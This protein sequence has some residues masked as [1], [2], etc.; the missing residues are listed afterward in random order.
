M[1]SCVYLFCIRPTFSRPRRLPTEKLLAVKA[2][3]RKM[4]EASIIRRSNSPW[5]S[6]L[7]IVP[8]QSG[9][10]RPCGDFLRLNEASTD[11]RYPLP[12]MQDFSSHL[13]GARIFSKIDLVPGYHQKYPW[14]QHLFQKRR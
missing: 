14:H 4:E 3:F 7:H 10:W 5:S 2:E 9:G 8:K 6:P 12:H 11:D 1:F 13:A